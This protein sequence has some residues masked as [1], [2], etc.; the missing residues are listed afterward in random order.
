LWLIQYEGLTCSMLKLSA[1]CKIQKHRQL[2][3]LA[4]L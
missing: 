4:H 1:V 2:V 3:E